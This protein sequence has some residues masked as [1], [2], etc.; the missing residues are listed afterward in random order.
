MFKYILH[1]NDFYE[2]IKDLHFG[3]SFDFDKN[4]YL[5]FELEI[6]DNKKKFQYYFILEFQIKFQNV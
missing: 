5:L 3:N 1:I 6:Q 2:I 4:S